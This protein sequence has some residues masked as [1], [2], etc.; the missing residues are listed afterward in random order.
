MDSPLQLTVVNQSQASDEASAADEVKRTSLRFSRDGS[1]CLDTDAVVL[2]F[3]HITMFDERIS[4]PRSSFRAKK[5]E[6][7]VDPQKY[8]LFIESKIEDP[9]LVKQDFMKFKASKPVGVADAKRW[10]KHQI[11]KLPTRWPKSLVHGSEVC[12]TEASSETVSGVET[13]P[14]AKIT[15]TEVDALHPIAQTPSVSTQKSVTK[16]ALSKKLGKLCCCCQKGTQETK[17]ECVNV[18]N[19]QS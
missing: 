14:V 16:I 17:G 3:E 15:S 12:S 13:I 4:V 9:R 5:V 19:E 1:Q 11:G 2:N 8:R 6:S 10:R 7:N 18:E